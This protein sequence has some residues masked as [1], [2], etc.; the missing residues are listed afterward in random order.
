MEQRSPEWFAARK[1]LVTA[2]QVWAILGL[3]PH[4]TRGDV[5]R[6]MV[7]DAMGAEPEFT[8]NVA[9]EYGAF[10]EA[11]AI[12][13]YVM[14]TGNRVDKA[15]FLVSP[16][17]I[18]GHAWAGCSP[19]GLL[20]ENGLLEVK[21][22]FD[23]RKPEEAKPFKTLAEQPHYIAQIQFSLWVTGRTWCDFWQWAPDRH[24]L[25]FCKAS[26]EWQAENL[27]KLRAFHAD[28]LAA[29]ADPKPYLEPR[30]A[31]IDTPQ[32]AKLIAEW[33]DLNEAIERAE[34]RKKEVLAEM[35][36]I[37]GERS[38]VI[39]GR[40]LTRIEKAGAVSY[41]KALAKY[42]PNAD[43]EPFRGKPSSYWVVK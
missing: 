41:A 24:D 22:P 33:D 5:L 19:D 10:H 21:C 7:R 31:E 42:A 26:E 2:S 35:V 38:A 14:E 27:P 1:G 36:R 3:S 30:R 37:A 32:A 16:E 43:L 40:N 13:D 4:A 15:G 25:T 18:D 23:L 34:E 20:G 17:M 8:G 39:S 9:T 6:R 29:L 28:Y 12:A 11:G